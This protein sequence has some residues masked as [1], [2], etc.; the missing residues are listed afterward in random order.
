MRRRARQ[1]RL[2]KWADGVAPKRESWINRNSFYYEDDRRYMR[3]LVPPGAKVLEL[4]CGTGQ[5]LAALNP[6]KGVGVDISPGMI[7]QARQRYPSFQFVVGDIEDPATLR[8]LDGPF[9][10]IVLS[11][12]IGYLEDC[13]RFLE[14]IQ[15]LCKRDTR[16][17]I[18]YFSQLWR[19]ILRIGE[20]LGGKMPQPKQNWLSSDDIVNLLEVTDFD[21]IKREWR[22][23]L[24][25]HAGGLGPIVNRYIGTLPGFRRLS[26]RHYVV[27]RST[28]DCEL[29]APSASVV[30]P[31]RNEAGNIEAAVSRLPQFCADLE[32]VF[33]EG[34]SQD[35]TVQEIKRVMSD[36]P[37]R[38]ITF[39]QQEGRGKA[40]AVRRGFEVARGDVLMILDAD[41]TVAPEDMGKFYEVIASGKANYVQGSRLVYAVE[42]GAMRRLNFAANHTFARIF[43]WLLNQRI[44]DTLCG[45]KVLGADHYR[46]LQEGRS[47]FGEFDPFGDFDLIFGASKLN[48]KMA[49]LPVRYSDRD[50]GSTQIS[51]FQDGLLLARMVIFAFRKLKAI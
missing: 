36:F 16:I 3:F 2:R 51:R 15:S 48:L 30:I 22:Q 1:Q 41:L 25:K 32:I 23:L 4:G 8:Q 33:V 35:D 47:Y 40:D 50:Y 21:L 37:D 6:S 45:T 12:A 49:E 34:H 5:L 7:D 28:R 39:V 38:D 20:L 29:G 9:D 13:Q 43:S 27:A 42:P 10:V 31:C 18:S 24:P 44:T 14:L 11:D 46:A 17:V 19:P 26:L